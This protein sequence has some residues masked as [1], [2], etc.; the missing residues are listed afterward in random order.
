MSD[1]FM[2]V[3]DLTEMELAFP[4]AAL[5]TL[6]FVFVA[7]TVLVTHQR[8]SFHESQ[9]KIVLGN[10][11]VVCIFIDIYIFVGL[12]HELQTSHATG[13]PGASVTSFA[14]TVMTSPLSLG[15]RAPVQFTCCDGLT[16]MGA[17]CPQSCSVTH[18][19]LSWTGER[20]CN[21]K[22]ECK[23]RTGRDHA[24]ITIMGKMDSTWGN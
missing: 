20:K 13:S 17:R 1:I 23:I 21:K 15:V 22:L 11:K 5:I 10:L 18:L 3:L 2:L 6:C 19:L 16:W 9:I 8:Y 12:S 24:P 14:R 4:I 7:R